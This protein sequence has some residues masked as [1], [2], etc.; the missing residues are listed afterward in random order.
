MHFNKG[1][2][3]IGTLSLLILVC[4]LVLFDAVNSGEQ[5][6]AHLNAT[7]Q[8]INK[9]YPVIGMGTKLNNSSNQAPTSALYSTWFRRGNKIILVGV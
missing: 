3:F 1:L 8:H 2:I 5:S 9:T 7:M 6:K 4:I